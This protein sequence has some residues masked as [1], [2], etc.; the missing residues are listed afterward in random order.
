MSKPV[1]NEKKEEIKNTE[2]Y[3]SENVSEAIKKVVNSPY[4]IKQIKFLLRT[5]P[6]INKETRK[7]VIE[8]VKRLRSER[9][10]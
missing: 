10:K 8:E 1:S 4:S 2:K 9:K 6:S 5:N 7:E 3:Y